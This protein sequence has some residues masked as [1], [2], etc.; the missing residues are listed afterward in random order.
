MHKE[1]IVQRTV[2]ALTTGDRVL[3]TDAGGLLVRRRSPRN[4][5]TSPAA[6]SLPRLLRNVNKENVSVDQPNI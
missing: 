3:P 4:V 6:D 5:P 2:V 1:L